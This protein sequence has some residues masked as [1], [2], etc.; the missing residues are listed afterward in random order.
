MDTLAKHTNA[1]VRK[2]QQEHQKQWRATTRQDVYSFLALVLLHG[3]GATKSSD[4][5]LEGIQPLPSHLYRPPRM[6]DPAVEA[7]NDLKKGAAA[8]DKL[9]RI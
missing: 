5:L 4:G 6:N 2:K 8:Y 9:C 3:D 1:N 7:A